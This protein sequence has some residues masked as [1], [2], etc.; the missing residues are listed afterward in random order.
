MPHLR[1]EYSDNIQSNIS[2]SLFK[3]LISILNK[4]AGAKSENCKARA[5]K[6]K[7]FCIGSDNK[8]EGFVHLEINILKG[9]TEKIKNQICQESLIIIKSYFQRVKGLDHIQFSLEIREMQRAN[10]F[11]SNN[12]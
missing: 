11:T 12:L 2:P 4:A 7:N 9:R 6:I 10:Y 5:I 3:K 8:K 1:L